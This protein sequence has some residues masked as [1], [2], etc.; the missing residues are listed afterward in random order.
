MLRREWNIP[1]LSITIRLFYKQARERERERE[2][3]ERVE[4]ERIEEEKEEKRER[5]KSIGIPLDS[6]RSRIL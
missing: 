3:V 4:R 2:R 6:A 5:I 1:I